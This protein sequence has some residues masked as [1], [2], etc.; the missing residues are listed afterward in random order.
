MILTVILGRQMQNLKN[1]S[2]TAITGGKKRKQADRV[3]QFN[4]HMIPT[5][6]W[7]F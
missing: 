5:D 3:G 2:I 6:A 7:L 4:I 1:R